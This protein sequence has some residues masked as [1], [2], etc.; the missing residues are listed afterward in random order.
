MFLTGMHATPPTARLPLQVP[1]KH[2]MALRHLLKFDYAQSP[3]PAN[4][5]EH[6]AVVLAV[7]VSMLVTMV[8]TVVCIFV[9]CIPHYVQVPIFDGVPG[10]LWGVGRPPGIR[11]FT[12]LL[13]TS[14]HQS[15]VAVRA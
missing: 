8:V 2:G 1:H 11:K 13:S 14:C 6:S 9:V 3:E 7:C 5:D 15:A 12:F 10:I 4:K